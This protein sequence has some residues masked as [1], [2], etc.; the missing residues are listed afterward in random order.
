[1][2]KWQR[3][4]KPVRDAMDTAGALLTD[5]QAATVAPLYKPWRVYDDDGK[6]IQYKIDDRRTFKG[7][8]YRCILNHEAQNAWN[9][10]DAPS[11]WTRVQ[12]SDTGEILPWVQ[13]DSTNGY[14]LGDKVTHKGKTWLCTE[15]DG[16]GNNIWEPGVFGWTEVME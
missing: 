11:L 15:V 2:S 12:T 6:P 8:L 14:K 7:L 3:G 1:M 10:A 9:P 5:E 13:P 16:A 4:A